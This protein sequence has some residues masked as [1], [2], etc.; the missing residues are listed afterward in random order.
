MKAKDL[1]KILSANPE[2][3]VVMQ[4][5]SEGNGYSPCDGAW[6]GH[7]VPETTWFGEAFLKGPLTADQLKHGFSEEDL[8]TDSKRQDTIFLVPVN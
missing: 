1:I 2:A 4:R 7:Y 3:E 5:D 6:N 8:T